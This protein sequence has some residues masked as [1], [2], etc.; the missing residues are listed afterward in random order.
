MKRL[1]KA[2]SGQFTLALPR[3]PG[4]HLAETR[5]EEFLQVL[6]DLLLEALS[7]VSEENQSGKEANNES[8]DHA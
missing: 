3:E 8:K 7:G 5:K 4:S 6:A 2:V 1:S